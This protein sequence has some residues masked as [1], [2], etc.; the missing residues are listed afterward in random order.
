[1]DNIDYLT[2]FLWTSPSYKELSMSGWAIFTA[3]S[4]CFW[5]IKSVSWAD[6]QTNCTKPGVE[7]CDS[8]FGAS[9]KTK[10]WRKQALSLSLHHT[11]AEHMQEEVTE[12][13]EGLSS[14]NNSF[15]W[16]GEVCVWD[17]QHSENATYRINWGYTETRG[18]QM[19]RVNTELTWAE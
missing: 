9:Y 2:V 17:R 15:L 4:R 16:V 10:P 3:V 1:M 11:H 18:D 14:L 13:T 19:S 8:A 6:G 7:S 12:D 5:L